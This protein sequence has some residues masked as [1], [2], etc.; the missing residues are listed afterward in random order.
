MAC[1]Q[2]LLRKNFP[3]S[4]VKATIDP[5]KGTSVSA[6]L[7]EEELSIFESDI[8][9]LGEQILATSIE[10][11]SP[12]IKELCN[13]CDFIQLCSKDPRYE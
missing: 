4:P 11:H 3:D 2:L 12:G 5:L 1:Y 13:Y 7:S 10:D 6:A 8:R 9:L